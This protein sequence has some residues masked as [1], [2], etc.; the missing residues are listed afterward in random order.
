[1]LAPCDCR[2]ARACSGKGCK[3]T[4]QAAPWPHSSSRDAHIPA[5]CIQGYC[6]QLVNTGSSQSRGTHTCADTPQH[7]PQ[8]S[9]HVL[10]LL[11][12]GY[13]GA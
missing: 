13:P 2:A 10:L 6:Q 1:M 12:A 5:A 8:L 3:H 11:R 7:D 4:Q 9:V